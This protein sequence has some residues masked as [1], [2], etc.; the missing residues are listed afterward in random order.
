MLDSNGCN[1]TAATT[2]AR[3]AERARPEGRRVVIVGAG[4]VGL[5]AAE[6]ARRRGLRRH[7]LGHPGATASATGSTA[8]RAA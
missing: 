2:V 4:A 8:A 7:G 5:R 3:L 6:A 1:T